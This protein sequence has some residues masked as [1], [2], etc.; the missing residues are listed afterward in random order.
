MPVKEVEKA[1]H[2]EDLDASEGRTRGARRSRLWPHAIVPFVISKSVSKSKKLTT[3]LYYGLV[4]TRERS[5]KVE[6][7]SVGGRE[8]R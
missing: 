8:R 6:L 7:E 4:L 3:S 2:G 5:V 1:I